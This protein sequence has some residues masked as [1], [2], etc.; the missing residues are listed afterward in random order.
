MF[1]VLLGMYP[2]KSQVHKKSQHNEKLLFSDTHPDICL[3]D[4]AGVTVYARELWD[5]EISRRDTEMKENVDR[6]RDFKRNVFGFFLFVFVYK[7]SNITVLE[8][9][10]MYIE[11]LSRQNY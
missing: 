5:G 1:H 3:R 7:C 4:L 10:Y 9:V 6:S 2:T 8:D 11:D